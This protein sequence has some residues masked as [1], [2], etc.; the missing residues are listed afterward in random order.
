MSE[1]NLALQ[2][3]FVSE[4]TTENSSYTSLPAD[5]SLL[6]KAKFA[7]ALS[8]EKTLKDMVNLTIPV[9]H[10]YIENRLVTVEKQDSAGNPVIDL[11]TGEV[12]TETIPRPS[13]VLLTEDMQGY[14]SGGLG[15]FL[16]LKRIFAQ[17]GTPDNWPFPVPI[18]VL[19]KKAKRGNTIDLQIDIPAFEKAE[20]EYNSKRK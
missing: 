12:V 18:K 10:V 4:I 1:N 11:E 3:N 20:K 16:S 19:T 7:N 6:D 17:I 13:I 5:M 8:T 2:Q 14:G 15:T 9:K